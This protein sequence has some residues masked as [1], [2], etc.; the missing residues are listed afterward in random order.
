MNFDLSPSVCTVE[1]K[2][3]LESYLEVDGRADT[4][5]THFIHCAATSD[6]AKHSAVREILKAQTLCVECDIISE[7]NAVCFL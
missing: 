1:K 7:A 3:G 5:K 2:G 6:T 4:L